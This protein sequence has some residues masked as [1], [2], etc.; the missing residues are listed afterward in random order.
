[1]KRLLLCAAL[2][3][4]CAPA[5][6]KDLTLDSLY[7]DCVTQDV[8]RQIS[9]LSFLFGHYVAVTSSPTDIYCND[10]TTNGQLQAAFVGWYVMNSSKQP[11]L[12]HL[13]QAWVELGFCYVK[14]EPT[15]QEMLQDG[16]G[17]DG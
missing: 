13:W 9:C 4:L 1:M 17:T 3:G 2:L 12:T 16:G 11:K 8:M 6:A 10:T 7:Q 14:K 15:E 5:T